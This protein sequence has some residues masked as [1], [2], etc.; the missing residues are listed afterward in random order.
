MKYLLLLALVLSSPQVGDAQA[1]TTMIKF[2]FF[3]DPIRQ[4]TKAGATYTF[5]CDGE[6]MDAEIMEPA[7]AADLGV[8]E[9]SLTNPEK[10]FTIT[11]Y[12]ARTFTAEILK[13]GIKEQCLQGDLKQ[14]P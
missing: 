11:I 10:T 13:G 6:A 7:G 12:R 8:D 3:K 9:F 14:V 5:R 2:R 4:V 1:V